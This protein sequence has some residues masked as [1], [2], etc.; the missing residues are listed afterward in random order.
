M[1]YR[2]MNLGPRMGG[3]VEGAS[4][5]SF[6]DLSSIASSFKSSID[7]SL[8]DADI[9]AQLFNNAFD[10]AIGNGEDPLDL[11]DAI[12]KTG[13]PSAYL[14]NLR[15]QLYTNPSG[16]EITRGGGVPTPS[17][18]G[19]N[20]YQAQGVK[21][22]NKPQEQPAQKPAQQQAQPQPVAS[23]DKGPQSEYEKEYQRYMQQQEEASQQAKEQFGTTSQGLMTPDEIQAQALKNHLEWMKKAGIPPEYAP[24]ATGGTT[25]QMTTPPQPTAQAVQ[26]PAPPAQPPPYAPVATGPSNQ[27]S[28]NKGQAEC[29]PP[30]VAAPGGGCMPGTPTG[31]G[32]GRFGNLTAAA[33]LGPSGAAAMPGGLELPPGLTEG[34]SG[35][36]M[37]SRIPFV[38][39][40]GTRALRGGW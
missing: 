39:G 5:P 19:T 8:P 14:H 2:V 15:P 7:N 1:R 9:Q 3:P 11:M 38:R 33:G 21:A 40:I 29:S 12:E 28:W 24:V 36:A 31:G 26:P 32:G 18:G 25:G 4:S 37:G 13:V 16:Q 22:G 6:G 34:A 30:M 27:Y 35:I 20:P 23:T 17:G 10:K